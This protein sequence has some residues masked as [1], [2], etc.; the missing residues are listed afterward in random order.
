MRLAEEEPDVLAELDKPWTDPG[1]VSDDPYPS[2]P[3]ERAGRLV[4]Q[5]EGAHSVEE[6]ELVAGDVGTDLGSFS[7]EERA[8]YLEPDDRF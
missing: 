5:D 7:P 1:D 6:A 4:A 8:M 3:D 2:D